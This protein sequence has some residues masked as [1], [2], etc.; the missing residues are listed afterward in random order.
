[1]A[2]QNF[3]AIGVIQFTALAARV[4]P[5]CGSDQEIAQAA[6]LPA[7]LPANPDQA[8]IADRI[9]LSALGED[10]IDRAAGCH[11]LQ[12]PYSTARI[13]FRVATTQGAGGDPAIGEQG[14]GAR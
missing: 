9:G 10:G 8:G 4:Y 1:M 3:A 12:V 7:C 2:V 13:V 6:N 5:P 11:A 14:G